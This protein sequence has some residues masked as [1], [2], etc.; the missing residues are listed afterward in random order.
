LA[1][2]YRKIG[3]TANSDGRR[4]RRNPIYPEI[5]L[6]TEDIYIIATEGDRYDTL[7]TT[8]YGDPTL[9]W[10]I[11]TANSSSNRASLVPTLGSQIRIPSNKQQAINL[12]DSLNLNR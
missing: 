9:W 3:T 6:S 4:Y 8:Y 5:P 7:A 10:I 12:F 11:S 1:N 2:R